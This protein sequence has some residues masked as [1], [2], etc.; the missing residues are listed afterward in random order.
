MILVGLNYFNYDYKTLFFVSGLVSLLIATYLFSFESFKINTKEQHKKIILRRKYSLFYILTFLAGARR[1]IFV[2]FAG[3]LMV[4]KFN[5]T[6]T[7]IA[8]LF[9]TSH[10][11]SIFFAPKIGQ[12][13][14]KYGEKKI[15]IIENFSLIIIFIL[16]A[17]VESKNQA[18]FLYIIDNVVFSFS[19]ALKSYFKKIANEA[20]ITST[21]S[22]SFTINHITAVFL[23]FVLGIIWVYSISYVFYLA[24]SF[25]LLSLLFSF[26]I[27][28]N[29]KVTIPVL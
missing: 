5:Y 8:L 4:E 18:A 22:V 15:L 16:Y 2:V 26:Q 11:V 20:D 28:T 3:L 24:S 9:L 14:N 7:D 13:I 10:F 17:F 1:Q 29:E 23:P 25:A 27:P 19:F 12:L 6:A 21:V